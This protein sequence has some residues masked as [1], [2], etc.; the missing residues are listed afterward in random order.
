[1][2]TESKE[3][4]F[5]VVAEVKVRPDV[6]VACVRHVGPYNRIGDAFG[7]L[8]AWAGPRGHLRFPET[9]VLAVYHDD[10]ELVEESKRRSSACIAVPKGAWVEGGAEALTVPGG[11]S[12]VA[13][14]EVT[15]D[16]V[17]AAW[18]APMEWVPAHGHRSDG[19]R[20]CYEVYL[21]DQRAHPEQKFI[22]DLCKPILPQ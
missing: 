3:Q 21:N 17:G 18:A 15:G 6:S 4:G 12:A 8:P 9:R 7:P 13:R 19:G 10:P 5:S 11:L 22:V 1:M 16:Q 14:V 20:P 2:P